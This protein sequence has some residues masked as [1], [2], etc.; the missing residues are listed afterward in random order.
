MNVEYME[1]CRLSLKVL[2]KS[3]TVAYASRPECLVI[4]RAQ[5]QPFERCQGKPVCFGLFYWE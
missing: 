5:L 3:V 2:D 4:S 1:C